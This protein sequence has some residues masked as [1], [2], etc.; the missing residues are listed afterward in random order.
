MKRPEWVTKLPLSGK[1]LALFGLAATA[2]LLVASSLPWLRMQSLVQAGQLETARELVAAWLAIDPDTSVDRAII[3]ADAT[4][5]PLGL[6]SAKT[7]AK[8]DPFVARAV[9]RFEDDP[10][11]N[12]LFEQDWDGW[13]RASRYAAARR[14][15]GGDLTGLIVLERTSDRAA[16]LLAVNSLYVLAAGSGVLAVSLPLFALIVARVILRP[17]RDLRDWAER[18]RDGNLD[19]RSEVTTGD[20][21]QE[22]AETF[23]LTLDELQDQQARLKAVNAA[24]DLKLSDLAEANDALDRASKLK[25]E[26]LANVSHELRTPLNSVI[27][28]A[29]LLL[30]IAETEVAKAAQ[31]GDE[32]P[33]SIAKRRRYLSNIV[34]AARNLLELI[35]SLLEL[36]KIE[37]G[38]IEVRTERMSVEEACRGMVTLIEPLA[39]RSGVSVD[40]TVEPGLPLIET[41]QKKFQQIVFNLLS[42]AVKFSD[43]AV[44]DGKPGRVALRAERLAL[45]DDAGDRIR[46][47]VIDNG[48][49]IPA[50]EQSRVFRKFERVEGTHTTATGGTGLGLSICRELAE[51]LQ[52]ELQLVSEVGAGAMFSLIVP[53]KLDASR[54]AETKL[55]ARF[56]GSLGRMDEWE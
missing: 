24:M 43:P 34:T 19:A 7:V 5:V 13:A 56:R 23:N 27:G 6:E 29:E 51:V 47:S 14:T 49:G 44:N 20:E 18:V 31:E 16:A 30:A 55:E 26:F 12:E 3:W 4:L 33:A 38:R 53:L 40:L 22:L 45:K 1:L 21:F 39:S 9:E 50:E 37:A 48:P 46:V 15:P 35:E 52:G 42:N 36:A 10:L 54:I 32:P 41:D 17:V 25:G 11:R 8:S 28:F 2:L